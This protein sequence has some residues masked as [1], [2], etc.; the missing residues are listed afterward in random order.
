MI[1]RPC[2]SVPEVMRNGVTGFIAAEFDDLVA[3]V[4]KIDTIS[5]AACREEYERRFAVDVMAE[6][7]GA[8]LSRI[9]LIN[10]R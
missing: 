3:A 6:K 7:Y 1:A 4:R 5:R 10:R 8:H 9:D 2:G